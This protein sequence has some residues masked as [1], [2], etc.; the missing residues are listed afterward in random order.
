MNFLTFSLS[1]KNSKKRV[2]EGAY[3]LIGGSKK[4]LYLVDSLNIYMVYAYSKVLS[5]YFAPF[6]RK[7]RKKKR[8]S[9]TEL[10]RAVGT[11]CDKIKAL[12]LIDEDNVDVNGRYGWVRSSFSFFFLDWFWLNSLNRQLLWKLLIMETWKWC[13]FW[14]RKEPMYFLKM[15]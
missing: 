5:W 9:I 7:E 11:D 13:N 14:L 6:S 15:K 4:L 12:R 8:M 1:Q 10:V 2:D 3:I